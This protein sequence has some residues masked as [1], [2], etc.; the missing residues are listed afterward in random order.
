MYLS[1]FKRFSPHVPLQTT[2]CMASCVFRWDLS[3]THMNLNFLPFHMLGGEWNNLQVD[4]PKHNSWKLYAVMGMF[5]FYLSPCCDNLSFLRKGADS[6]F[7]NLL[8]QNV[9]YISNSRCLHASE[10]YFPLQRLGRLFLLVWSKDAWSLEL[11]YP[12]ML[13]RLLQQGKTANSNH[14]IYA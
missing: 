7:K 2:W 13:E 1:L 8:Q 6:L 4:P 12:V 3:P 14:L 5:I 9:I 10:L 11:H